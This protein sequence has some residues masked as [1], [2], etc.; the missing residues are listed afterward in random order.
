MCRPG[1]R[2]GSVCPDAA[3]PEPPRCLAARR[4]RRAVRGCD[5][6]FRRRLVYAC[7]RRAREAL[8]RRDNGFGRGT[9]GRRSRRARRRVPG[10]R[11]DGRSRAHWCARPA[12]C[13][14]QEHGR[15]TLPRRHDRG[16]RCQ[17]TLGPGDLRRRFRQ[18]WL[19]RLVCDEL[20]PEPALSQSRGTD[21]RRRG[22]EGWSRGGRLVHRVRVR[23]FRRRWV[24]RS[25]CRRL[26]R[27][28]RPQPS[29]GS[30]RRGQPPIVQ[31][32]R[33]GERDQ[34]GTEHGAGRESRNGCGVLHL[35]ER[36]GDVWPGRSSR[37]SGSP[38]PEQPRWHLHRRDTRGRRRGREA[39]L[40]LRR[41]LAR[42]RR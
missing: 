20:R 36:T 24:A 29:A 42:L 39:P 2:R 7:L 14:V 31:R 23:R 34:A 8:H 21:V 33:H 26:R 38:V 4:R 30:N 17:R 13:V 11:I 5:R 18:R 3:D 25:L 15:R 22:R 27:P 12:G 32:R 1:V 10:E 9:R 40:R 35:P 28:R 6:V 19:R 41:G 37:R 16:R